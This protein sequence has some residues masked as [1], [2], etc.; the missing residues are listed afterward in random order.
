MENMRYSFYFC[1]E[2]VTQLL[3][4]IKKIKTIILDKYMKNIF[5]KN[6]L[7]FLFF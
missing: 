5:I 2:S 4:T 3:N 6:L 7:N 1:L